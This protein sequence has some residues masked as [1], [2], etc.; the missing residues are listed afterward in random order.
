MKRSPSP[1][2]ARSSH[3]VHQLC[4]TDSEPAAQTMVQTSLHIKGYKVR[5]NKFSFEA[6]TNQPI[7]SVHPN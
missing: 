2:R 5:G 7:E 1:L 3:M 4:K 6:L